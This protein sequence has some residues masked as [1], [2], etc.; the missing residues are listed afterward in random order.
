MFGVTEAIKFLDAFQYPID[1]LLNYAHI[2]FILENIHDSV[3]IQ[4]SD[5]FNKKI[6]AGNE[7]INFPHIILWTLIDLEYLVFR[8]VVLQFWFSLYVFRLLV[9]KILHICDNINPFPRYCYHCFT[10]HILTISH[11]SNEYEWSC[12]NIFIVDG[13]G[14]LQR[15]KLE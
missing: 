11:R 15:V 8:M 10:L 2:S 12:L 14:R 6:E 5:E 1:F 3:S 4:R 9:L 13:R 7:K